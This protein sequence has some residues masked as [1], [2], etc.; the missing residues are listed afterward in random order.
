MVTPLLKN[1]TASAGELLDGAREYL[2]VDP[3]A[4]AA[5]Q[6]AA[7]YKALSDIA[8][9]EEPGAAAERLSMKWNRPALKG[10]YLALLWYYEDSLD[11]RKFCVHKAIDQEDHFGVAED[12]IRM[13][14]E[15]HG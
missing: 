4:T 10:G 15:G 2:K 11:P 6:L 13:L 8:P 12:V 14:N 7:V 1:A 3:E 5:L 9:G